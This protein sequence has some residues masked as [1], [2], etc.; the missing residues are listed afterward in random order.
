MLYWTDCYDDGGIA[1]NEDNDD[2]G[3]PGTMKGILAKPFPA[4]ALLAAIVALAAPTIATAQTVS[5]LWDGKVEVSGTAI[6]FLFRLSGT[7]D[8]LHANFFNGDAATTPSTGGAFKDGTVVLDFASYAATLTASLKDGA[9]DG[10]YATPTHRYAIHAVPHRAAPAGQ[11][12]AAPE[13]AGDWIIPLQGSG[14][15]EQDHAKG[16]T[17]WRLILR[18]HGSEATATILRVDGDTGTL[19]G[20]YDGKSFVLSHFAGERPA[21]LDIQPRPDGALAL[22]LTDSD[23]SQPLVAVKP[24]VAQAQNLGAPTDPTHQTSVR[25]PEEPLHFRFPDLAGH[26]VADTDARFRGKVVLLDVMGSWCPNCHDEAPFLQTLYET[27]HDKGLEIVALD[28]E[29]GDQVANPTRLRAFIDR[30]KLTYEVLLCGDRKDVHEK[31]PQA[32][33]LS[34][35][36]TTFFVGRDGLV[37]TVHAGFTSP[38]SAEYDTRLKADVTAEVERLLA[39]AGP[40]AR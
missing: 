11:G 4:A 38:G 37:K 40:P 7:D 16:E 12:I 13:I 9:L 25:S 34:A 23:G 6:P 22:T 20:S 15:P 27:Y 32:V 29:Q 3:H 8:A 26:E 2:E 17:A 28:F 31:L 1:A 19:S 30:Y 33:N 21:L 35:W 36:P 10:I 14:V 39:S 5:G 24:A 18:Q